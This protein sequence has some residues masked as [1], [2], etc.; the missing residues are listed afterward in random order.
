M[1]WKASEGIIKIDDSKCGWS[2]QFSVKSCTK[3]TCL[4]INNIKIR[5]MEELRF[6]AIQLSETL[7]SY[8]LDTVPTII[9]HSLTKFA[10]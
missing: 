10:I 4:V 9:I 1:I 5:C 7:A 6:S 8:F 2:I 3:V